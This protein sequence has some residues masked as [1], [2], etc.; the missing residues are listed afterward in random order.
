[1]KRKIFGMIVIMALA[2]ALAAGCGK[3]DE[4]T[5]PQTT[6]VTE[7]EEETEEEPATTEETEDETAE[8]E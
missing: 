1:M 4:E 2:G 5:E 8:E 3:K 7:A 6:A